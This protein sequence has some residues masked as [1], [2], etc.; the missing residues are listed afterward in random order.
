MQASR[1]RRKSKE[2]DKSTSSGAGQGIGNCASIALLSGILKLHCTPWGYQH[3][4]LWQNA[5]QNAG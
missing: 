2:S 1:N 4:K 3:R 5:V